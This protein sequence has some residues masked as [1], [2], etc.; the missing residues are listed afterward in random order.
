MTML[1]P[2][3]RR[4]ALAWI[5]IALL[6]AGPSFAETASLSNR[7]VRILTTFQ[8]QNPF[9]PWL[10]QAPGTRS[11]YG[12]LIG[13]GHV[14]TTE[15]LVRN[16]T[17]VELRHPR[18][19]E[20]I[21]SSVTATDP[22]LNLALLS[23]RSPQAA[24]ALD[25]LTTAGPA[26]VGSHL[27]VLQFDS[28]ENIQSV[29]GRIAQIAVNQLPDGPYAI[30][31]YD[32]L[33]ELNIDGE[34]APVADGDQ[35]A[36]LVM[37]HQATTRIAT[38]I[39]QPFLARFLED[40]SAPPYRGSAS[41]GF[42]WRPLIDPAKRSFLGLDGI[43]GGIQV[44]ASIPGTAAYGLLQPMDVVLTW[45][46]HPLDELGYYVD[47]VFGR[48]EFS[49]L[50]KGKASPG[51]VVDIDIWRDGKRQSLALPLGGDPDEVVLVPENVTGARAEYLVAGGLVLR[52]LDM[53]MLRAY[54]ND[55]RAKADPKL[56]HR[57]LAGTGGDYRPG[58]RV[59]ILTG[60]L[61]DEINVGYQSFRTRIV[62]AVN[63][64]PIRNLHE[65]FAVSDRDGA[66]HRVAL[67]GIGIDVVLDRA[68]LAD[69]NRRLMEH[70]RIPRLEYRR[71]AAPPEGHLP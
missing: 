26:T 27:Q 3:H 70:Y 40:A 62:T 36:G 12:V 17:Q 64:T 67:D 38:F 65:V 29:D 7:V 47:D 69:A 8:V 51:D 44:I 33:C 24:P 60:I 31:S 39:G 22:R 34:G 4:A 15:H 48:Q 59:V 25:P 9:I 57:Y 61:P 37:N 2:R 55:W 63:G 53:F 21:A 49:H 30:L 56:L 41:A 20:R 11:G 54:G 52:E 68:S 66:I 6:H 19:G 71:P 23:I 28:G 18:S 42:S 16:A 50:V 32:L 13:N 5:A 43:P 35:L 10:S 58:D 1:Q 14:L 46:G 45:A